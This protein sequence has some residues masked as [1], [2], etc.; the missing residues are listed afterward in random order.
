MSWHV[1]WK[2]SKGRHD[3]VYN[4]MQAVMNHVE[5]CMKMGWRVDGIIPTTLKGRKFCLFSNDRR[6]TECREL[7]ECILRILREKGEAVAVSELTGLLDGQ[8][9]TDSVRKGM[10]RRR[11]YALR[12]KGLV[13][14]VPSWGNESIWILRGEE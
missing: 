12:K 1:H 13:E 6:M 2:D 3:V 8:A 4:G 9:R 5:T 14:S 10:I 11:M 7:D